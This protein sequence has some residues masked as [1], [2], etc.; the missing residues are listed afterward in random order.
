MRCAAPPILPKKRGYLEGER[1]EYQLKGANGKAIQE[2]L[3]ATDAFD[4]SG[5]GPLAMLNFVGRQLN[6]VESRAAWM[7][8][9]FGTVTVRSYSD[10]HPTRQGAA[11]S[12]GVPFGQ[13]RRA[14][15]L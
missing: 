1:Y 5:T 11:S 13:A 10:C 9:A 2:K 15:V 8:N 4:V 7:E 14:P 3:K 12:R 6:T